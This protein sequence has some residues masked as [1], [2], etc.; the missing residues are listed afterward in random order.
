MNVTYK[1]AGGNLTIEY[2]ASDLKEAFGFLGSCQELFGAAEECENCKGSDLRPKYR[3][4]KGGYEFYSLEC[5]GCKWEFKF[6]QKKEGG[7]YPKGWE[8][9]YQSEPDQQKSQEETK[10]E[11]QRQS[12]F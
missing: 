6:G 11:L 10:K 1:A 9:P 12:P 4:T 3:T 7:L 5:H 8:A 2:D